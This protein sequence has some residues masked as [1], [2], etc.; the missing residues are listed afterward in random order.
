[1]KCTKCKREVEITLPA[2]ILSEDV[3]VKTAEGGGPMLVNLCIRC[4]LG[5]GL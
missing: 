1:M 3:A 2:M 4:L 5:Y